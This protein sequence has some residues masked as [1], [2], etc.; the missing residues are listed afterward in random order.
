MHEFDKFFE[1][2]DYKDGDE[3]QAFADFLASKTGKPVLG[4]NCEETHL[5]VGRPEEEE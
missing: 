1:A 4:T 5:V 2:G 3:P